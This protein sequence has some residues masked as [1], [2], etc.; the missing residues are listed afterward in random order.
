MA[1]RSDHTRE[2]LK[3]LAIDAALKIIRK[4]GFS[5]FSARRV[6]G[7]IGYTI[8][9][10]YNVFGTYDDFILHINARTLD[11]W[12]EAMQKAL[13]AHKKGDPVLALA[14]A[15]IHFSRNNYQEWIALFEHHMAGDKDVPQWYAPKMTR[16]FAMVET[17]LLQR[18]G[19]NRKKAHRAARVLWAGIHGICILSLSHKLDRVEGESAEVLATS[20]VEHYLKG[21]ARG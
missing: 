10:I 21:L 3:E 6:A 5:S 16:F 17:Q 8:G 20:F 11:S 15:Y 13:K 19:G 14:R 1:R 12:Y 4:Q 7:E 18:V 2:E 9:T